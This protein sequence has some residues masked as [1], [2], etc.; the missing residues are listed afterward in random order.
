MMSRNVALSTALLL[1]SIL[2]TS[3]SRAAPAA[4]PTSDRGSEAAAAAGDTVGS[5][6]C[7]S[8]HPDV[9][10]EWASSPHGA[11]DE[12]LASPSEGFDFAIGSSWMQA[13]L[14][15]DDEGL[16]RLVPRCFDVQARSWRA[17]DD[18]L[19]AIQGPIMPEEGGSRPP[20][21]T[22]RRSFERDC[23]GCHVSG[24]R[25]REDVEAGRISGGWRAP[26]ID[27]EACH[28]P[29]REHVEAWK[30][31]DDGHPMLDL[32][33]L[34]ARTS[35]AVCARCHGG[36][37][38][39]S[40]FTPLDAQHWVTPPLTARGIFSHGA[41]SGQ[42]YQVDSFLRSACY[43]EGGLSCNGCH[44]WHGRGMRHTEH[45]DAMCTRCHMTE[46][47]REHTHHA[48]DQDGGRCIECH[49]PKLLE[50]LLSHQRDH[51]IGSPLPAATETPDACTACHRDKDKAWASEWYETWWGP[52]PAFTLDAVR[53]VH[54][55]RSGSLEEARP[56]L[57]R[58][59]AH[60]YP[61]YR[62]AAAY[63]LQDPRAIADEE[64][65]EARLLA[66][67]L[68][69]AGSDA[70]VL[71]AGLKDPSPVLRALAYAGLVERGASRL[72]PPIEDLEV[73]ARIFRN[74]A[75]VR[76]LLARAHL[77][78]GNVERAVDVLEET[79]V[80]RRLDADAWLALAGAYVLAERDAAAA[81][82]VERWA[83]ATD[84]R[85]HL[86]DFLSAAENAGEVSLVRAALAAVIDH[87]TDPKLRALAERQRASR[88]AR[89]EE[90]AR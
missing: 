9:F 52:P 33:A 1:G 2:A 28:G 49:M 68:A 7:E 87:A 26:D 66:L 30:E 23:S 69:R 41:A 24:T 74:A 31:L 73:A 11:T 90:V 67:E 62:L 25:L 79:V 14:R 51:R 4:A 19:D 50:G 18:V 75:D 6:A 71:R 35:T 82:A 86:R 8:C 65:P 77:A 32:G 84:A 34:D 12:A 29:G 53:G 56:L 37:P 76:V 45:A 44:E 88:E 20:R 57:E 42:V 81:G 3:L 15:K 22:W 13:Y 70:K 78:R 85:A 64:A 10:A 27:C 40:E 55:A 5:A 61:F 80:F 59:Q 46:A 38:V 43:L 72:E 17:V 60:P 16:H 89:L 63:W 58:A 36:P 54:L 48:M 39:G 21:E 83:G 47:S